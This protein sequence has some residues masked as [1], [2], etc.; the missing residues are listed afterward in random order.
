MIQTREGIECREIIR[1]LTK[2]VDGVRF[3]GAG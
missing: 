1:E 3:D 2:S